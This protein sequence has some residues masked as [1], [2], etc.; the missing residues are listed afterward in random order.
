VKKWQV[1]EF[2]NVGT[3][4]TQKCVKMF[5]RTLGIYQGDGYKKVV[6]PGVW[7]KYFQR[8]L[9]ICIGVGKQQNVR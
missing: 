3:S 9:V 8:M 7:G 2:W 5:A 1:V 4:V 6:I